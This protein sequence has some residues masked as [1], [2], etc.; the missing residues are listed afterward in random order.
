MSVTANRIIDRAVLLEEGETIALPCPSYDAM[1][2]LRT[3]LYK[4]KQQLE[5]KHLAA[6]RALYISR[7][8][9]K[10]KWTIFVTKETGI[11]G[12]FIVKDG[13]AR[14]LDLPEETEEE[15]AERL[16]TED[17]ALTFLEK[18][19]QVE[20]TFEEAASRIEAGQNLQGELEEEVS[21]VDKQEKSISNSSEKEV[22][23]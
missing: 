15:R 5:K 12:A 22:A 19:G 17:K 4:V 10:G 6:A 18:E 11:P 3:Q 7:K 8:A 21:V 13:E 20:L 2:A 1:E 9:R 23:K 16:R 14:P